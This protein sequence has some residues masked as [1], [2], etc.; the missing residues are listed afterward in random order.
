MLRYRPAGQRRGEGPFRQKEF[1]GADDQR[2]VSAGMG[3]A[4]RL[5]ES[6]QA[7]GPKRGGVSPSFL[8]RQT[9]AAGPFIHKTNKNPLEAVYFAER[10]ENPRKPCGHLWKTAK[11]HPLHSGVIYGKISLSYR[12]SLCRPFFFQRGEGRF[13]AGGEISARRLRR[14]AKGIGAPRAGGELGR[15][16][17]RH[18]IKGDGERCA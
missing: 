11:N 12:K 2:A 16:A 15:R 9:I 18:H 4:E 5:N 14:Q 17:C 1:P 13:Q 8:R 3:Q 10:T 7:G 6:K